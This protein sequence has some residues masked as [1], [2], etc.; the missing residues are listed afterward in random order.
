MNVDALDANAGWFINLS[1]SFKSGKKCREK[2]KNMEEGENERVHDNERH[3]KGRRTSS[4]RM[5][6]E[7]PRTLGRAAARRGD[8]GSVSK[9]LKRTIVE[10]YR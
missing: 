4:V 5:Q 2:K 7:D 9:L 10:P 3:Y 1:G 8:D 6:I